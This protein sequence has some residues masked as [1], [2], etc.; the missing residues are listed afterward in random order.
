MK[1]DKKFLE[2]L[3]GSLSKEKAESVSKK[4]GSIFNIINKQNPHDNKIDVEEI[5]RFTASIWQ[6]D[7]GDEKISDKEIETFIEK[8]YTDFKNTDIS[9]KDIKKF[10][11]FFAKNSDKTS[12][13]NTRI[14][15]GDGNYSIILQRE[16]FEEVQND[17]KPYKSNKLNV[18][19]TKSGKASAGNIFSIFTAEN[20]PENNSQNDIFLGLSERQSKSS[21]K[22]IVSKGFVSRKINY[23]S[24]NQII[25]I[26]ETRGDVTTVTDANGNVLRL[27]TKNSEAKDSI[28]DYTIFDDGTKEES[29]FYGENSIK[30]SEFPAFKNVYKNNVLVAK[31]EFDDSGQIKQRQNIKNGTVE[32]V[33]K[34]NDG[35]EGETVQL[36]S[37][38]NNYA[39]PDKVFD[40]IIDPIRQNKTGD[41]WLLDG[42]TNLYQ[43]DWGR[44]AIDK[45]I[46]IDPTTGNRTIKLKHAYGETKEFVIT[47]QDLEQAKNM[48]SRFYS[49]E[50]EQ[51]DVV[52]VDGKKELYLSKNGVVTFNS[53]NIKDNI[54]LIAKNGKKYTYTAEDIKA[55]LGDKT[56]NGPKYSS[57]DLTVLACELAVERSRKEVGLT[58]DGGSYVEVIALFTDIDEINVLQNKKIVSKCNNLYSA[59]LTTSDKER[60]ELYKTQMKNITH[61]M[62]EHL[63]LKEVDSAAIFEQMKK[64][65]QNPDNYSCSIC[66]AMDGG[67]HAGRLI[68]FEHIDGKDYVVYAHSWDEK[69]EI[70]E[71]LTHF[72][73]NHLAQVDIIEKETNQPVTNSDT[74]IGSFKMSNKSNRTN[75]SSA[76]VNLDQNLDFMPD[77]QKDG[78]NFIVTIKNKEMII[79]RS[80]L[81]VAKVSGR[82]TS[83]DDD[84]PILELAV[85]RYINQTRHNNTIDHLTYTSLEDVKIIDILELFT[86]KKLELTQTVSLQNASQKDGLKFAVNRAFNSNLGEYENSYYPI[87]EIKQA[88][89]G[90]YLI[91]VIQPEDTSIVVTYTEEEYKKA[92]NMIEIYD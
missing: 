60:N 3:T 67:Y 18:S 26:E 51:G 83:I 10:L 36:F 39:D 7:N 55:I 5:T 12:D 33:T 21:E 34:F 76:I 24:S 63:S 65:I 44:E 23:N 13:N 81:D 56:G 58:L 69:A 77:I 84:I 2:Q 41:C 35:V 79:S 42:L 22:K 1:I 49:F 89:D 86:D 52:Y 8:N 20:K 91:S 25:S 50:V 16:E 32:S 72:V 71:E 59:S 80:E 85:E 66:L 14:D 19:N 90:K 37:N 61:H 47:P 70:T 82:Y 54:T 74:Q 62:G 27:I 48:T 38:T 11:E 46:S 75:F 87:K 43:K 29:F 88:P 17:T 28:I 64:I 68:R 31:Y 78:D 92:F 6:E 53:D 9:A 15:N 45:A 40:K 4:F 30:D 73:E 57:G